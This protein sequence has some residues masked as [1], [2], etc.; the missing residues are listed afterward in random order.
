MCTSCL[1]PAEPAAAQLQHQTVAN[2]RDELRIG[3]LALGIADRVAEVLLQGFQIAPVP[4]HLDGVAD[5]FP[6]SML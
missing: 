5:L 2:H 3:G 1:R 4:G 6:C